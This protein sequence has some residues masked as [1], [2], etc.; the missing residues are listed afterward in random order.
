M[1]TGFP[2]GR[3]PLVGL[4][5]AGS[6]LA[7]CRRQQRSS[8][9]EEFAL[10][11]VAIGSEARADQRAASHRN[12]GT[13]GN[14]LRRIEV[15]LD[16]TKRCRRGCALCVLQARRCAAGLF[17][18]WVPTAGAQNRRT[19]GGAASGFALEAGAHPP[20]NAKAIAT[21]SSRKTISIP[22][23][24]RAAQWEN[25]IGLSGKC[26]PSSDVAATIHKC[27]QFAVSKARTGRAA[28]V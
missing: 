8:S 3:G 1:F 21:R 10:G 15:A 13:S 9:S 12:C 17:E 19:V 6:Q 16:S 28:A 27:L 5:D 24:C 22:L 4:A 11:M 18:C 20:A 25:L 23:G 14:D 7:A 26:R 2:R